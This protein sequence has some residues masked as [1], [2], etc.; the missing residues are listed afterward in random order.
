MLKAPNCVITKV[1]LPANLIVL[2]MAT[3][4]SLGETYEGQS[5]YY[6]ITN[7]GESL[8]SDSF[9]VYNALDEFGCITLC[10]N[11]DR[12]TKGVYD[13]NSR[14]CLLEMDG[15]KKRKGNNRGEDLLSTGE[16]FVL[17]S[18]LGRTFDFSA[19]KFK[20]KPVGKYRS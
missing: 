12:C 15:C 5:S 18:K 2:I 10:N 1:F 9:E 13:H 20:E 7:S 16:N 14:S 17:F 4:L 6:L 8:S 11:K 3:T 19:R